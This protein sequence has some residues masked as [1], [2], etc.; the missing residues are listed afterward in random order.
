MTLALHG[1]SKTRQGWLI[2]IA[3]AM[4]AFAALAGA[5]ALLGGGDARA[6]GTVVVTSSNLNGV[7]SAGTGYLIGSQRIA[8]CAHVVDRAV[9]E[10]IRVR[11]GDA[12]LAATILCIDRD[13]DCAVLDLQRAPGALPL[14]LGGGCTWK[15]AWDGF[16]F[17]GIGNGTGVTC[18]GIVSNTHARDDLKRLYETSTDPLVVAVHGISVLATSWGDIFTV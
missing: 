3:I 7:K 5:G 4:V 14:T 2:A 12:E 9:P 11:F 15:A 17:P 1:K 18:S 13:N 16:G 6:T 8:T 10:S